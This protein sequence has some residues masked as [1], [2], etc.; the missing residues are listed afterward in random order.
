MN[1]YAETINNF[2]LV[3]VPILSF[4]FLILSSL[5]F[6]FP[7]ICAMSA[8]VPQTLIFDLIGISINT[9]TIAGILYGIFIFPFFLMYKIEFTKTDKLRYKFCLKKLFFGTLLFILAGEAINYFYQGM[10]I[11]QTILQLFNNQDIM[12]KFIQGYINFNNN[13]YLSTMISI[14]CTALITVVALKYL[15]YSIITFFFKFIYSYYQLLVIIDSLSNG[16]Y[17]LIRTKKNLKIKI[18]LRIN[19]TTKIKYRE[20]YI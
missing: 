7:F 13:F 11:Y 15:V 2:F 19:W 10:S 5:I 20:L 1:N 18:L 17:W 6:L 9:N 12:L 3:K 16:I 4:K 8:I 14:L